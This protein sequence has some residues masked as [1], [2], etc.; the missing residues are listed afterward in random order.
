MAGAAILCAEA[1][2]RSGSGMVMVYTDESNR[3]IVQTALPEAIVTTYNGEKKPDAAAR[4][5][6][7]EAFSWCDTVAIGPGLS[8]SDSAKEILSYTLEHAG[9]P[10]VIDADA[11][12]IIASD[13]GILADSSADVIITP[14][15]GEMSRLTGIATEEIAKH[16]ISTAR[17]FSKSYGVITVLKDART[18]ITSARGDVMININGNNGMATAGSGDV[19]TGIIASVRGRDID[20]FTSASLGCALHGRAGDAAKAALGADHMIAG[21]II[22]YI[23]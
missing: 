19:L 5:A 4:K 3:Q 23:R 7:D 1:A 11:L 12:N 21:D 14:H 10:I 13:A 8:K 20:S 18:V 16:M 17:D 6:L 9:V 2:L 22:K 15:V